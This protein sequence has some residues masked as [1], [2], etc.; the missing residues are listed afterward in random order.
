MAKSHQSRLTVS[1]AGTELPE[2]SLGAPAPIISLEKL[3]EPGERFFT[4]HFI[5]RNE[6]VEVLE[7]ISHMY[8]LTGQHDCPLVPVT[9][10]NTAYKSANVYISPIEYLHQMDASRDD[11][12]RLELHDQFRLPNTLSPIP[13]GAVELFNVYLDNGPA[14]SQEAF[15]RGNQKFALSI[16][17]QRRPYYFPFEIQKKR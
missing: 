12:E 5:L 13:P 10:K 4:L 17:T 2:L 16:C 8:F 15:V 9:S 3:I 7:A 1:L 6:G 11:R 14:P